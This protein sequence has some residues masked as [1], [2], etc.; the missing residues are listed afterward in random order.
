MGN[1]LE[2]YLMCSELAVKPYLD[3]QCSI[4]KYITIKDIF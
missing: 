4:D 3:I 1:L 2:W